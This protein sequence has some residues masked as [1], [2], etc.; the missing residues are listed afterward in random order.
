M[1]DATPFR[2][3]AAYLFLCAGAH[4]AEKTLPRPASEWAERGTLIHGAVATAVLF[5]E[6]DI[7]LTAPAALKADAEALS[8][9][10]TALTALMDIAAECDAY[11]VEKPVAIGDVLGAKF[12][13]LFNGTAD[14][15]GYSAQDKRTHVVDVKTGAEIIPPQSIQLRAY[16]VGALALYP[17]AETFRLSVIQP[18]AEAMGLGVVNSADYTRGEIEEQRRTF[19]EQIEA[20]L[21]PNPARSPGPWCKRCPALALCRPAAE[22]H[23]GFAAA[24]QA[25]GSPETLDPAVIARIVW[26]ADVVQEFIASVRKYA[27]DVLVAGGTI[28]QLKLTRPSVPRGIEAARAK[29]AIAALV[30][31]G[32]DLDVLAPRKIVTPATL[33]RAGHKDIVKNFA[34]KGVGA[35]RAV[36]RDVRGKEVPP[37]SADRGFDT[38]EAETLEFGI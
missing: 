23:F 35:Y 9:A 28:P 36:H 37:P 14:F 12:A 11:D 5:G 33:E 16:A 8:T 18:V 24:A 32:A 10:Q 25:A 13:G 1:A 26:T 31:A 6:S 17:D 20:A 21:E 27:T 34:T 38:Q 29:D 3:S 2:P 15:I 22:F 19:A 7:E 4:Q 30:E